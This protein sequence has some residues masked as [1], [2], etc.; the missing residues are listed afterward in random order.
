V[1]NYNAYPLEHARV[2]GAVREIASLLGRD[3]RILLSD[4]QTYEIA[5]SLQARVDAGFIKGQVVTGDHDNDA[6]E[7]VLDWEEFIRG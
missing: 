5:L 3:P 4:R 1:S 2:C 6:G 7:T